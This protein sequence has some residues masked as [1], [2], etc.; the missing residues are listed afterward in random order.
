MTRTFSLTRSIFL[1]SLMASGV[2]ACTTSGS[3]G[4]GSATDGTG[5]GTASQSS[6]AIGGTAQAGG[7]SSTGSATPIASAAS[8]T[9][10]P[11]TGGLGG[12]SFAAGASL[13]P[14]SPYVRYIGRVET[15]RAG[16]VHL[17]WAGSALQV[18]VTNAA[19]VTVDR[20]SVV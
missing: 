20:K 7:N 18:R 1:G 2:G 11:Y 9:V 4:D 15:S 14:N 8:G 17:S 13:S 16:G 19:T 6:T 12:N 5:T 10:N 3:S